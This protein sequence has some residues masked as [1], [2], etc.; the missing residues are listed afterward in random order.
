MALSK[1]RLDMAEI[2]LRLSRSD[3]HRDLVKAQAPPRLIISANKLPDAICQDLHLPTKTGAGHKT[4]ALIDGQTLL[5]LQHHRPLRSTQQDVTLKMAEQRLSL[6]LY[7]IDKER[8]EVTVGQ[9]VEEA[10]I[11]S[12]WARPE[13][14]GGGVSW[15]IQ[16]ERIGVLQLCY[17][18][19][20]MHPALPLRLHPYIYI[21]PEL[22]A[23]VE[24][25]D[26]ELSTLSDMS[27]HLGE[28][29]RDIGETKDV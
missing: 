28:G 7:R 5:R 12:P 23:G 29:R 21:F 9:L 10:D 1:D 18:F 14:Q 8:E 27:E 26:T 13:P 17:S 3:H 24:R 22:Q 20:V 6:D 2:G 11:L 25:V 19:S 4:D 15:L 16:L